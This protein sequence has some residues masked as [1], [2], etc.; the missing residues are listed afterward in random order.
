MDEI[1]SAFGYR[2]VSSENDL[3]G[4]SGVVC[5]LY[6]FGVVSLGFAVPEYLWNDLGP[7]G[8][9]ARTLLDAIERFS[10]AV[11]HTSGDGI[12]FLFNCNSLV[13][14]VSQIQSRHLE[15][16]YSFKNDLD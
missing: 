14:V 11:D 7:G 2:P 5:G 12:V 1:K 3:K 6:P 4:Y 8:Y 10:F 13:L 16:R 9:S 15:A